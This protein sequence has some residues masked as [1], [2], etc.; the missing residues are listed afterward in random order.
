[1]PTVLHPRALDSVRGRVPSRVT[2]AGENYDVDANGRVSLPAESDVRALAQAYDVT[3]ETLAPEFDEDLTCAGNDGECSRTV[4]NPG[5]YC[6]QH[7]E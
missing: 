7:S 4:E 2:V 3:P 5:D 6:W 1:M